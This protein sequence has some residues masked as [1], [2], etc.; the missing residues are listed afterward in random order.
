MACF[1]LVVAQADETPPRSTNP[2][3]RIAWHLTLLKKLELQLITQPIPDAM[4]D[5]NDICIIGIIIATNNTHIL[6][7]RT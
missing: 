1:M 3:T 5:K 4:Q 7:W 6:Q 2:E